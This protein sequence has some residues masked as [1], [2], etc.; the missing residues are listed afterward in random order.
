MNSTSF[1][2]KPS[3]GLKMGEP[4]AS[5]SIR[6]LF[7]ILRD[8]LRSCEGVLATTSPDCSSSAAALLVVHELTVAPIVC[9]CGKCCTEITLYYA[10]LCCS[11]LLPLAFSA[12]CLESVGKN[13]FSRAGCDSLLVSN[14]RKLMHTLLKLALA[15]DSRYGV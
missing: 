6:E 9:Y 11:V 14:D 4:D 13:Q 5:G 15:R 12:R 8:P 10:S 1:E 3:S 7:D 2:V